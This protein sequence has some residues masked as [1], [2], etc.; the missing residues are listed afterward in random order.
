MARCDDCIHEKVCLH[1]ANIQTDTYAYMGVKYDTEKCEHFK[2]AAD[3]VPKSEVDVWK[4][5]RFNLY[6]KLECYKMA[7]QKVARGIFE[8]I[9]AEITEALKCNYKRRTE[10]YTKERFKKEDGEF[11]NTVNGKIDALRGIDGFI[12]EIKKKYIKDCTTCQHL[13]SCE[14]NPFGKCDGY[15]PGEVVWGDKQ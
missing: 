12:D 4:Q 13:V 11:I 1:R 15:K 6:Q 8:E 9:E 7:S 3:V 10:Y 2:A 14:P 5:N